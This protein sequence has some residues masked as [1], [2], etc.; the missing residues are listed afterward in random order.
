MGDMM[1]LAGH[2]Y[3]DISA[4]A[5]LINGV[6]RLRRGSWHPRSGEFGED[7]VVE[8]MDLVSEETNAAVIAELVKVEGLL[9]QARTWPINPVQ[10]GGAWLEW[11]I[12]AEPRVSAEAG[13]PSKRAW[14]YSGKLELGG[15]DVLPG[16]FLN[17][18]AVAKLAIERHPLW[19]NLEPVED[20]FSSYGFGDVEDMT[21]LLAEMGTAPARIVQFD[22][23]TVPAR[24]N[25]E[26][27][28]GFRSA[29]R[30][31]SDYDPLWELED[32]DNGT[33]TSDAVDATASG[34]DKITCTFA[35][36]EG[37]DQR[38]KVSMHQ[39]HSGI[40]YPEHFHGRYIVLLRAKVGSS[41]ECG[42]VLRWGKYSDEDRARA[43]EVYISNTSWKLIELGQVM[44]PAGGYRDEYNLAGYAELATYFT[45][46]IDAE[47]LSGSGSLDM[48]CLYLIPADHYLHAYNTAEAQYGLHVTAMTTPDDQV[49]ARMEVAQVSQSYP[50]ADITTVGWFL[51][52]D[53][54][55]A[56]AAVQEDSHDLTFNLDWDLSW[57][58]RWMLYRGS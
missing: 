4:K 36:E 21:G 55:F 53:L 18:R 37:L 50:S 16:A 38:T 29:N 13:Y 58:P 34:G 6:L 52:V 25:R 27:W 51:P 32:G 2:D 45:M 1:Y 5:D 46:A 48:D 9:E 56:I 39:A 20:S 42:V 24:T 14:V 30:G 23:N 26:F 35:T 8:T 41:T 40:S 44:I 19:E 22:F 15:G 33:D 31:W 43:E 11:G 49:S 54:A 28:I 3:T 12:G 10:A 7:R 17:D 57:Y 47:R